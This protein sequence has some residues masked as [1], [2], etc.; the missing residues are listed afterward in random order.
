M[1]VFEN[2]GE[3]DPRLIMLIGVNVKQ[4]LSPI[5]FFGTGLKYAVAC[6]T[7]WGED[8]RIQSGVHEFRFASE[9]TEIR[10]RTFGVLSMF[11]PIDK[12]A[13]GFTTELG[14]RWEPW[15]VYRELWCN[16]H[17]EPG[18]KVYE[19]DTIPRPEAG[20]TRVVVSGEKIEAAHA[21]RDTFILG[22]RR[23]LLHKV[24]GLEIYEGEGER[25]FYRGIAVQ[26]PDKPALYTYNITSH[27]YLT[28][29]RTASSWQTDGVIASGLTLLKDEDLIDATLSAPADRLESRLDYDFAYTPGDIWKERAACAVAANPMG[30]PDSVRRKFTTPAAVCPSCGRPM[31]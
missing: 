7:R 5:G 22:K 28:E 25:I 14:K 26:K 15:M 17:D 18:S 24:D 6:M 2:E 1:I 30:T 19:V 4:T 23:K 12:A 16:A 11:S 10:G 3:I 13:L 20:V 21:D 9:E 29:D 8:I 27:L 31:A